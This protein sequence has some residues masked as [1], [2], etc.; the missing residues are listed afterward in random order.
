[1]R[2][3]AERTVSCQCLMP[4]TFNPYHMAVGT[5]ARQTCIAYQRM[6]SCKRLSTHVAA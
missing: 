5:M 2:L 3:F 6:L 1:M 4:D